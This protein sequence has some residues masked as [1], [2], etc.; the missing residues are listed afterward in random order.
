MESIRL[1]FRELAAFYLLPRQTTRELCRHLSSSTFQAFATIL[2]NAT[3]VLHYNLKVISLT[4]IQ[5][6]AR[7]KSVFTALAHT[8][9]LHHQRA[10]LHDNYNYVYK[11]LKFALHHLLPI[12][13]AGEQCTRTITTE[14][15]RQIRN[16]QLTHKWLLALVLLPKEVCFQH[17]R[18]HG[19]AASLR[20]FREIT[21]NLLT[22]WFQLD[23]TH[24]TKLI[25]PYKQTLQVLA[26]FD[27][28]LSL[29]RFI[30]LL[31]EAY[32]PIKFACNIVT[33]EKGRQLLQYSFYDVNDDD[34]DG[35]EAEQ[36]D[37]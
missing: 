23:A 29:T 8:T 37:D 25:E 35:D 18:T 26:Q 34:D 3:I 12:A 28:P 19:R 5:R 2:T 33:N 20:G 27:K 32:E 30:E 21:H 1:N 13:I 9:D 4:D 17:I 7:Y 10:V 31:N 16:L 11:F 14:G 6:V 24:E 22:G 15:T 36:I